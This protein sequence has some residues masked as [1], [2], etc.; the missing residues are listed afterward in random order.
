MMRIYLS[1]IL[2]IVGFLVLIGIVFI[3]MSKSQNMIVV[4]TGNFDK[5]PLEIKLGHFQD[6][7]C[8]MVIHSLDYASEVVD[9]DGKT[10]FFH[11]HGGMVKWLESKEFKDE[12]TIWVWAKDAKKW[13]DGRKA[14]YSK[15]DTTPMR[16]GFGAYENK[17]DDFVSFD[18]M[19]LKMLRGE[20]L[21][22]PNV[23]KQLGVLN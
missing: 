6:S 14:W 7:D 23:R 5:K 22:N 21:T 9:K 4:T 2:F 12:T 10:W 15:T 3:S 8:G 17:S 13:I 18:E 11:D 16:Y 1:K 19:S 20:N